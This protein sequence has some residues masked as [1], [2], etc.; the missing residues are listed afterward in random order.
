MI[1]RR[2]ELL[3]PVGLGRSQPL[4]AASIELAGVE[5]AGLHGLVVGAHGRVQRDGIEPE[6]AGQLADRVGAD[7]R[8][9]RGHEQLLALAVDDRVGDLVLLLRD[10]PAPDRV[11]LGP[12]VLALVIEPL[13]RL[14]HHDA[15]RHAVEPGADAAIEFRRAGV[16]GDGVALRR[17]A[18]RRRPPGRAGS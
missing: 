13:G 10:Q 4:G 1:G 12:D 16:D 14:V 3:R 9:H 17:I 2:V 7:R 11:A 5:G 6:L 18:D 8:E 15:E